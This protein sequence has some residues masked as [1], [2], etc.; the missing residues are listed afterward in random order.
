MKIKQKDLIKTILAI[1]AGNSLMA[2]SY[3]MFVI[4]GKIVGGGSGGIGIVLHA[5]FGI[6]PATFITIFMVL[7]FI[8]GFFVLEKKF[9]LMTLPSVA[10]YPAGIFLFRSIPAL[11]ELASQINN[12]LVAAIFGG[13][14]YGVGGALIYRMG[15]STGGTDVPAFI[16]SK[17]LRMN[18][19]K[20][21]LIIDATIILSGLIFV[22]F[23]EAL[24]GIIMV[25][26]SSQIIDRMMY[27]GSE[28]MMMLIISDK[29][30]EINHYILHTLNRGST[31]IPSI[32]SF[33]KQDKPTIQVVIS[34]REYHDLE[35]RCKQIDPD[36]FV[37]VLNAKQVYGKGFTTTRGG[38]KK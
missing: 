25:F 28:T 31:L 18:L 12:P 29:H 4:P 35:L 34:R 1:I 22:G 15:G 11:S 37:I 30:E 10:I 26:I 17:Y 19:D 20:A 36:S 21:I 3:V 7:M 32:G 5:L 38:A 13:M 8:V 27:G 9:S 14:C 23:Q 2:F 33:S 16:L 24:I 6:D